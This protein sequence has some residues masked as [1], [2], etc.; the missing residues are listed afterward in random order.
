MFKGDDLKLRAIRAN[1]VYIRPLIYEII[2]GATGPNGSTC[3]AHTFVCSPA[4][5]GLGCDFFGESFPPPPGIEL[6]FE[7]DATAVA[8][9][10]NCPELQ[11]QAGY[12]LIESESPK[13][14]GS[15]KGKGNGDYRY[16]RT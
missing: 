11:C 12:T 14:K 4:V 13:T 1:P 8:S 6:F 9:P 10:K 15:S 2:L 5:T 16:V 7:D 3:T